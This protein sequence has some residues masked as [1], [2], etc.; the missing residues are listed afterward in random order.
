MT[1][2]LPPIEEVL[3]WFTVAQSALAE[4]EATLMDNDFGWVNDPEGFQ[5]YS[6]FDFEGAVNDVVMFLSA[7]HPA[8]ST[9]GIAWLGSPLSRG[10]IEGAQI[11]VS[12]PVGHHTLYLGRY[13]DLR[14][15][16]HDRGATGVD[17]LRAIVS[18]LHSHFD[19]LLSDL[20]EIQGEA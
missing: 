3:G 13:V 14:Q 8:F 18:A 2:H 9:M 15:L 7:N 17:G 11:E 19:R 4:T 1:A 16:T 6:A 5:G 10:T 12:V 20:A